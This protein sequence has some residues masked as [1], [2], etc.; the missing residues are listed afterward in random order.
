MQKS[1]IRKRLIKERLALKPSDVASKSNIIANR[2]ISSTL[3]KNADN[4][5]LYSDFRSEVQTGPMIDA[6]FSLGKRVLMPKVRREDYSIVFIPILSLDELEKGDDGFLE[7]LAEVE[8]AFD[9]SKINLFIIP[10]VAYDLSGRRLGLG[11]G[12]YDRAL[13]NVGRDIVLAP[14]YEFQL[15]EDVPFYHHDLKVGW[16]ATEDRFFKTVSK[17]KLKEDCR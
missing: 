14:A 12:C 4:I 13:K 7:P 5:A 8:K 2:V 16:I 17:E 9:V 11:K 10:G 1:L 6:A 3:F 15:M